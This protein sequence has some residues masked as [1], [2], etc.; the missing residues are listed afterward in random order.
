MLRSF[1]VLKMLKKVLI[2]REYRAIFFTL[3]LKNGGR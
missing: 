2:F 1:F 3:S